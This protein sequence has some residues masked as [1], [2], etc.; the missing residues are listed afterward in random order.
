MSNTP[1]DNEPDANS[2]EKVIAIFREL[3]GERASRLSASHYNRDAAAAIEAAL[4]SSANHRKAHDIAFNLTDWAS[5][6]A[7]IVAVQLFPERFSAVEIADGVEGFLLYAPNHVAAAA[8]LFG[9][10]AEDIF[11]VAPAGSD[12]AEN[13]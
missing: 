10:P 11:G 8:V 13:S 4:A 3:V 1:S 6:A 9:Y 7:F 5:D 12:V 2:Q